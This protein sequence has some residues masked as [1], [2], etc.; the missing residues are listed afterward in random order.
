MRPF[1]VPFGQ[2][3][4]APEVSAATDAEELAMQM[5]VATECAAIDDYAANM[6]SDSVFG[7]DGYTHRGPAAVARFERVRDMFSDMCGGG[8]D[9][10]VEEH[11]R[12][13]LASNDAGSLTHAI[14][15]VLRRCAAGL[16][17]DSVVR[18]EDS[19]V[20]CCM[21]AIRDCTLSIRAHAAEILGDD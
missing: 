7:A 9:A 1:C 19:R 15:E 10:V 14:Q 4:H 18:D 13:A 3:H 11:A 12:A 5:Q 17:E 8:K 20:S 21:R 2:Q 16:A 6:L